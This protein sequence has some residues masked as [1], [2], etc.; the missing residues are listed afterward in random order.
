MKKPKLGDFPVEAIFHL[1]EQ[2]QDDEFMEDAE[3]VVMDKLMKMEMPLPKL[4]HDFVSSKGFKRRMLGNT[5]AVRIV[6]VKVVSQLLI[7]K[8]V[9]VIDEQYLWMLSVNAD[10]EEVRRLAKNEIDERLK[11]LEEDMELAAGLEAKMALDNGDI[12]TYERKLRLESR[13]Y[14]G[15][16]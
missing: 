16:Y 2:K 13:L 5:L 8:L 7:K 1:V 4:M 9:E 3:L 15:K 11:S 14:Y 10:V 12:K 6:H